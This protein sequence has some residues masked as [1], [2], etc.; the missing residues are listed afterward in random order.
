MA[1]AEGPGPD[2][3]IAGAARSGTSY[4]AALLSAH[5]EID[6]GA[7]KEPNYF[8]REFHRGVEW[9]ERLYEPRQAGL[10]RLD[11]S[12]SYTFPHFPAALSNLAVASPDA[13]VVYVVREPVARALSHYRL[14]HDY[15]GIES[16]EDFGSAIRRNPIYLG[17]GN[18][19]DWLQ[20]LNV[21]FPSEQMLLVPFS[22]LSTDAETVSN[23][24]AGMLGLDPLPDRAVEQAR[25]HRNDVVE[26][27]H[28][29]VKRLRRWVKRNGYYP[30]LRR[31]VG[32]QRLRK[33]RSRLTRQT[34][35]IDLSSA[36]AT[37]TGDDI[38]A[39]EKLYTSARTA[40]MD[41]LREQDGRLHLDWRT[42]WV[43]E[44]PET[45]PALL[46]CDAG[47]RME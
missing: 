43:E 19:A 20:R 18:Y 34:P 44:V 16:A 8:S 25:V 47:H 2:L 12:V 13:V 38:A 9:Y 26:F 3:V 29:T 40:V 21:L 1:V 30:W 4:L 14:H 22:L 41:A 23:R 32:T 36:L 7:V 37:C 28:A 17:A 45:H 39:M 31:R 10:R 6:A 42:S 46:E 35:P 33:L 24:I 5:P 15:F 27:R 11:S